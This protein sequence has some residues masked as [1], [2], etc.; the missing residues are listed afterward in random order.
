MKQA[1]I[2]RGK[3]AVENKYGRVV[4]E[5]AWKDVVARCGARARARLQVGGRSGKRRRARDDKQDG[6]QPGPSSSM[7][8]KVRLSREKKNKTRE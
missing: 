3:G 4:K 6:S 8:K 2:G 1:R 5:D 7:R